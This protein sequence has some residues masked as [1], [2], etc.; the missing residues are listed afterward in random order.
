MQVGMTAATL[1]AVIIGFGLLRFMQ[2]R[3]MY[4]RR[5]SEEQYRRPVLLTQWLQDWRMAWPVA[6]LMAPAVA[7]PVATSWEALG[8]GTFAAVQWVAAALVLTLA[9]PFATYARNT[10]LNR[11]HDLDRVALLVLGAAVVMH[12]V[13]LPAFLMQLL[14]VARQFEH[15]A[16]LR[17]SFTPTRLSMDLLMLLAA[18]PMAVV[19]VNPPAEALVVMMLGATA[20]LYVWPGIAKTVMCPTP[21]LW[22]IKNRTH[23]LFVTSH[24]QGWLKRMSEARALATARVLRVMDRPIGLLTLALELGAV[25][26]LVGREAAVVVLLANVVLHAAIFAASG[27]NFWKWAVA[28]AALAG[29]LLMLPEAAI[30]A[31]FTP[32]HLAIGLAIIATHVAHQRCP[33]LGWLD[34]PLNNHFIIEAEGESGRVY[35]LSRTY[36]APYDMVFAQDRHYQLTPGKLLVGTYGCT[37]GT[38]RS[39]YAVHEA[40]ER[41]GGDASAIEEVR[42]KLGRCEYDERSAAEFDRFVVEFCRGVNEGVRSGANGPVRGWWRR[43][44]PPLHIWS[45]W[46]GEDVYAGQEPITGVRVRLRETW[47]DGE[48]VRVLSD[49]VVREIRV[50]EVVSRMTEAGVKARAA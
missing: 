32:E 30:A 7:A 35:R 5:M 16:C 10:F 46:R 44:A 8:G 41:T 23:R 27:I 45:S 4:G 43:W 29:L 40:L 31:V 15:P 18:W 39:G 19:L 22:A 24:Q 50:P 33:R 12:P 34:T 20:S 9:W 6:A 37:I 42:R 36:F 26:M 25:L 2:D 47:Y 13:A 21:G 28:D 49:A 48:R 38:P 14:V 11:G 1:Y 3:W 17:Y